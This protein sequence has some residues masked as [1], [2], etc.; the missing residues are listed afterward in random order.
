MYSLLVKVCCWYLAKLGQV[1]TSLLST[2]N[3]VHLQKQT[4]NRQLFECSKD[5]CS[6][7]SILSWSNFYDNLCFNYIVLKAVLKVHHAYCSYVVENVFLIETMVT[8]N[9]PTT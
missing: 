2:P 7:C 4:D 9:I 6:D 1:L 8:A 5:E 3:I